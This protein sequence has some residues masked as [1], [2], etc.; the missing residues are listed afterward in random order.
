MWSVSTH[1]FSRWALTFQTLLWWGYKRSWSIDSAMKQIIHTLYCSI[2]F[3][4]TRY[5]RYTVGF[6]CCV[7]R[8]VGQ[9]R[10]SLPQQTQRLISCRT[11]L[12]LASW[13]STLVTPAGY[14]SHRSMSH[15]ASD[16]AAAFQASLRLRMWLANCATGCSSS[17]PAAGVTAAHPKRGFVCSLPKIWSRIP[18]EIIDRGAAHGWLKIKIACSDFLT[19]KSKKPSRKKS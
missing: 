2:P 6:I 13:C 3:L 10:I 1:R 18:I 17:N 14:L 12:E 16:R 19:W 15:E 4:C 9:F 8:R 5:L 11:V 7:G